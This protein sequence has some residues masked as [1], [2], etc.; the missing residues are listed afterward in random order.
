MK[1]FKCSMFMGKPLNDMTKEEL[2]EVIDYLYED[3]DNRVAQAKKDAKVFLDIEKVKRKHMI[4][5]GPVFFAYI[6]LLLLVGLLS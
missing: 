5:F 3:G 4:H 6:L 2:L 1:N